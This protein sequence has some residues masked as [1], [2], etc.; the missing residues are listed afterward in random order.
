MISP[1][2]VLPIIEKVALSISL[3]SLPLTLTILAPIVDE[4]FYSKDFFSSHSF[5]TDS[6]VNHCVPLVSQHERLACFGRASTRNYSKADREPHHGLNRIPGGTFDPSSFR[7]ML[8]VK[9]KGRVIWLI[10]IE[11]HSRMAFVALYL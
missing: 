8:R 4:K 2:L 11:I 7:A 3:T 6:H 10:S 9:L 1:S 5:F